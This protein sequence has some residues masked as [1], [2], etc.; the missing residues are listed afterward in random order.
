[1]DGGVVE[2]EDCNCG[3]RWVREANWTV[4]NAVAVWILGIAEFCSSNNTNCGFL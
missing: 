4:A 3:D 1:M 2:L